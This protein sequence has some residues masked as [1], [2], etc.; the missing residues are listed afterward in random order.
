MLLVQII[1]LFSLLIFSIRLSQLFFPLDI[2]KKQALEENFRILKPVDSSS[3]PKLSD[4]K[5]FCH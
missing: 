4:P 3:T 5:W 2:Q 1:C